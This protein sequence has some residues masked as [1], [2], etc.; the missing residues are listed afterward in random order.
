MRSQ[1]TTQA[2]VPEGAGFLSLSPDM[3]DSVGH[4]F[5]SARV[6]LFFAPRRSWPYLVPIRSS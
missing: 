3:D 2:A 6:D 1:A 5:V 4:V